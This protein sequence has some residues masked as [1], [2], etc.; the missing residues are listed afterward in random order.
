MSFVANVA[1]DDEFGLRRYLV[2]KYDDAWNKFVM[3]RNF[4]HFFF[5]TKVNGES[6]RML[7]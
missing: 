1:I 6:G 2:S 5:C 7:F 4:A 3:G